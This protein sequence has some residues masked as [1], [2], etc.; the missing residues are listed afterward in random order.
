MRSEVIQSENLY[1]IP[2]T[3]YRSSGGLNNKYE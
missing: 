2:K 3:P 1:K